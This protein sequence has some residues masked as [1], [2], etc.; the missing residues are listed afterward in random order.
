MLDSYVY[1]NVIILS[2]IVSRCSSF[3]QFVS[4]ITYLWLQSILYILYCRMKKKIF[5]QQNE[6]SPNHNPNQ[7][8]LYSNVTY[9]FGVY[10]YNCVE[11]R[12]ISGM[13]VCFL[14]WLWFVSILLFLFDSLIHLS[15]YNKQI[16]I[17]KM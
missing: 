15:H 9:I 8:L 3:N 11:S 17:T 7:F 16:F 12:A 10:E 6:V 1:R 4:R 14:R 5:H 13:N 2:P